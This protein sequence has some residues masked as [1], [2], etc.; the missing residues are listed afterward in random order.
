MSLL[1]AIAAVALWRTGQFDT[2]DIAHVVEAPEPEVVKVLDE[3]RRAE[4][5]P[6]LYVIGGSS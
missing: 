5:G 2:L 3:A 4:R 1:K 6:D